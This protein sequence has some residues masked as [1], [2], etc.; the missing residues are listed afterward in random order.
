MTPAEAYDATRDAFASILM[1]QARAQG[2]TIN[3]GQIYGWLDTAMTAAGMM[4]LLTVLASADLA[5]GSYDDAY[6][7][8]IEGP[9]DGL[10]DTV[11]TW[12]TSRQQLSDFPNLAGLVSLA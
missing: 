11:D 12:K 3:V 7:P 8:P 5:A 9:P 4:P 6:T 1:A 10:G 2:L